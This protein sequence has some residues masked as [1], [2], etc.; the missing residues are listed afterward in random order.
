[1]PRVVVY[2]GLFCPYCASA[3]RLLKTKGVEFE[4]IDVSS[5]PDKR[6]EMVERSGGRTTVPQI[7]IGDTHVGGCDELFALED[8]G[9]LDALLEQPA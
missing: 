3:M 5:A 2:S 4:E 6:R 7:W 9:R 8:D 1:M